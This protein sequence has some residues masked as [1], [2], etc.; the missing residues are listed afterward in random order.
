VGFRFW[1]W[2]FFELLCCL[3]LFL[4]AW[5]SA[6]GGAARREN[7]RLVLS[8]S[9]SLSF[10]TQKGRQQ[11]VKLTSTL[12]VDTGIM[13]VTRRLAWR[14]GRRPAR[15]WRDAASQKPPPPPPPPSPLPPPSRA[16]WSVVVCFKGLLVDQ[17][18][19]RL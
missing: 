10:G 16:S 17:G 8:W 7:A 9:F 13:V 14:V 4:A 19:D 12:G 6:A 5:R 2:V 1:G 18:C 3:F 11:Q 15:A